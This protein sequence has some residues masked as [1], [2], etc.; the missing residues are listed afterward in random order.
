M[1]QLIWALFSLEDLGATNSS[2]SVTIALALI[3]YV[4][5]LIIAVILLVNM[6]VALLSNTY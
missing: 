4:V 3:L 1:S 2:D 5:F 6:M